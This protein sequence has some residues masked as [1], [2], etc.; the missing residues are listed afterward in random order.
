MLIRSVLATLF[1]ISLA[2]CTQ[3]T[4]DVDSYP[5]V[6]GRT[7]LAPFKADLKAA[8]MK[9]M[10][11]GPAGAIEACRTEA[12]GIAD[13][14]SIDGVRMGRSS[15]RLRNPANMPPGWLAPQMK[16]W[17]EQGIRAEDVAGV[18][19]TAIRIS[20]DRFGY[21]EPIFTQPLCLTCHGKELHPDVVARI[22]ELYPD[23]EATGFGDGD[24]RGVFWV[25]F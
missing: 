8:L 12:P 18:Q 13:A 7:L 3:E 20:E 17:A 16:K 23:D 11:G 4:A 10:E 15:H 21:A 19:G 9:G 22:S 2:A 5:D 6:E 24:L 1:A 14:L 25:E